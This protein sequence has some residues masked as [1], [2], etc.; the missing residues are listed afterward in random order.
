MKNICF[1]LLLILFM[2]GCFNELP[3]SK[4]QAYIISQDFVKLRLSDPA[5]ADFISS[6][7][8]AYDYGDSTFMVKGVVDARNMFGGTVRTPY[9]AKLRYKGGDWAETN[10]WLL[11]GMEI[12]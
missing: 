6:L 3:V 10:N 2:G 12:N 7:Y 4:T 8:E 5:N 9:V 1:S 11:I